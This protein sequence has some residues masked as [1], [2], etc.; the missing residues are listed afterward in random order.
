ML[1]NLFMT[2][3]WNRMRALEHVCPL[4]SKL[5]KCAEKRTFAAIFDGS[6]KVANPA[7]I[8]PMANERFLA[9]P[10]QKFAKAD[11]EHLWSIKICLAYRLKGHLPPF[12]TFL[13]I[14]FCFFP[15]LDGEENRK[16]QNDILIKRILPREL[17]H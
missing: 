10:E 14:L 5:E 8:H 4:S 9:R 7:I 2:M 6:Q 11:L 13:L 3:V 17:F 1:M 12:M 16:Y 15:K